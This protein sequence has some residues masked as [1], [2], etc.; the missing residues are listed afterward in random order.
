V[1]DFRTNSLVGEDFKQD[2]VS[3]PAVN[4]VNPVDAGFQRIN[5]TIDFGKHAFGD[6]SFILKR[7]D[8]IDGKAGK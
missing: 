2:A 7:L 5:R 8:L 6:D 1:N 4:E 3:E